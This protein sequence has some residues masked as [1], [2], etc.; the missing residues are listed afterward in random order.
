MSLLAEA[1]VDSVNRADLDDL[2]RLFAKDAVLLNPAGKF[3]GHA[4]ISDFYTGVVFKGQAV[5]EIERHHIA[6][7]AEIVQLRASSPLGEPG[8]FVYAVDV[9]TIAD[10]RIE[11]LEIYY[12]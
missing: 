1:Y 12:R 5:T 10:G 4:A 8:R 6:D 11:R 9:F 3:E 7:G 2:L